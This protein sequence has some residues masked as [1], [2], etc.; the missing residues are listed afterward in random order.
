MFD[1][2]LVVV[3]MRGRTWKVEVGIVE[4]VLFEVVLVMVLMSSRI[5]L[6]LYEMRKA[7]MQIRNEKTIFMDS[8]VS[9]YRRLDEFTWERMEKRKWLEDSHA[10]LISR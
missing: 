9:S 3:G 4:V 1:G 10:V 5:S 7:V 6:L 8:M 2:V